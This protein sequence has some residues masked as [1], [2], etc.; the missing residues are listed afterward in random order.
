MRHQGEPHVLYIGRAISARKQAEAERAV[1]ETQLRQSQKMEAIG[2]LT[3]GIAHDF[4]NILQGVIGY[5]VLAQEC[6]E[7]SEDPRIARYLNR[8]LAA[9]NRAGN[10][11]KQMLTF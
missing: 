3:G 9:A 7:K 4:N 5:V 6:L 11:I 8:A 1:L 10:L 2:Q